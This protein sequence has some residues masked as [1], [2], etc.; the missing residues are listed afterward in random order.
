VWFVA[1]FFLIPGWF[2]STLTASETPMSLAQ[3][4][5]LYQKAH[6]VALLA[7]LFL[8]VAAWL[9]QTN[10]LRQKLRF[11][12]TLAAFMVVS[13]LIGVML[14]DVFGQWVLPPNLKSKLFF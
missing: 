10:P 14:S 4:I 12:A 11:A 8:L 6:R 5:G 1:T 7:L 9:F 3:M 13:L 2:L